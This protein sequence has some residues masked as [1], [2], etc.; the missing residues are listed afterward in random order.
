MAKTDRSKLFSRIALAVVG[1]WA[2]R[3]AWR[4][5][6]R[7]SLLLPKPDQK[8]IK[9][10]G[11]SPLDFSLHQAVLPDGTPAALGVD[12]IDRR[13]PWKWSSPSQVQFWQALK[14]EAA[15]EGMATGYHWPT[16]PDPA[17]VQP[18]APGGGHVARVAEGWTPQASDF[19]A[20]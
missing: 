19:A 18:W 11:Y 6:R 13:Y 17:H 16:R 4:G 14:Q 2:A 7:A 15:R 1:L 8:R 9:G 10:A 3:R 5:A 12:L 20:S